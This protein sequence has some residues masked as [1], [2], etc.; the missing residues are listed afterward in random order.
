MEKEDSYIQIGSSSEIAH[1][2]DRRIYRILEIIPAFLSWGTIIL[3][4]LLSIFNPLLAAFLIIAFDLYWLLKTFNLAIHQY[5]N[6]KRM[7]HNM[8]VDW[9]AMLAPLHY[10]N[11]YHMVLLPY[12]KEKEEIVRGALD[13]LS[14]THYNSQKIIVV[15][16]VEERAGKE[17]LLISEKMKKEYGEKFGHFIAV[18]HPDGIKG[19]IQGKGPNIAYAG[20]CATKE[21]VEKNALPL[22]NVIVSAFDIDTVPGKQYFE[23]LTWNFLTTENRHNASFQPVPLYNN[24]M[25]D[26][27]SFS[28]VA[29]FSST[30]WQMIQ[31][32]RVEKLTT[33][34]SHALSLKSLLQV[35]FWQKNVVSDDSRIFW[36]LY[37]ANDGKYRVI[38]IGYPVSMDA[39]H[40]SS[41]LKTFINIYKQHLRWMWG[42]ENVPYML[43]GFLKNKKIPK[44]EKLFHTFVYIESFWSAATAPLVIF[45]LGWLP[46]LL[47]GDEFRSTVISYN[48]P[49]IT[50]N[51]MLIAMSGLILLSIIYFSFIP[52]LPE[53]K[54]KRKYFHYTIGAL[55][56]LLVPIA[57]VIFGAIPALHAQTNLALGRRMGF[58]VTPKHRNKK[59]GVKEKSA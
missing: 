31:Q 59:D 7:K 19:E 45:L 5:H 55:Q 43:Y 26:A 27:P 51:L 20:K 23:C 17:A 18:I 49:Y 30:S 10:E 57:I 35:D 37:F 39:N 6:W 24:N 32:E 58:W 4:V 56:W 42:A 29:A 47:G 22:E 12:Y 36:N 3:V 50:S 8:N 53:H 25:W 44:K 28:R 54:K 13:A 52:P 38:P 2:K 48:L 16:A 21:I 15:L 11:I 33:F 9:S 34:S 41:S 1:K 14:L 40:A 46:I